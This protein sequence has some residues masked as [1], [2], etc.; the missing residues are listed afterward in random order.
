MVLTKLYVITQTIYLYIVK[1]YKYTYKKKNK[2]DIIIFN[3]IYNNIDQENINFNNIFDN[4]KLNNNKL[5]KNNN[6]HNNIK[7]DFNFDDIYKIKNLSF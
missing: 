3:E 2:E 4:N 1:I 6:I 7:I 5:N